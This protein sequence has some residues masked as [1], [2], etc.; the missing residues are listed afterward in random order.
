[1]VDAFKFMAHEAHRRLQKQGTNTSTDDTSTDDS[2]ALY[3]DVWTPETPPSPSQASIA[4]LTN[5]K[6]NS[7]SDQDSL[8]VVE[9]DPDYVMVMPQ[10]L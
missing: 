10:D 4:S 5:T 6:K 8:V 9:S 1:M 3:M 2:Q 7:E